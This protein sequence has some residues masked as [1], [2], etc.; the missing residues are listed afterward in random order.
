M[1]WKCRLPVVNG[2][3]RV[4]V[5][6]ASVSIPYNSGV[7]SVLGQSFSSVCP[8]GKST[9][10]LIKIHIH[11]IALRMAKTPL[12]KTPK[13]DH[14][15]YLIVLKYEHTDC[16][17]ENN[18]VLPAL[19]LAGCRGRPWGAEPEGRNI[20]FWDPTRENMLDHYYLTRI[21]SIEQTK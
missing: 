7:D 10:Y 8:L 20:S 1:L 11:P 15:N 19:T 21:T 13:T 4:N 14:D 5:I 18:K 12:A 3:K 6:L 9:F 17:I 2:A 16:T